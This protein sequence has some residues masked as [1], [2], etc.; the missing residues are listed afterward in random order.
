MDILPLASLADPSTPS[1]SAP[2][3]GQ[4][5]VMPPSS[6]AALAQNQ[7]SSS[8]PAQSETA[9]VGLAVSVGVLVLSLGPVLGRPLALGLGSAVTGDAEFGVAEVVDAATPGAPVL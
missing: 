1:Q 6:R 2:K 4:Y 7:R 3:G 5:R 8:E 9:A